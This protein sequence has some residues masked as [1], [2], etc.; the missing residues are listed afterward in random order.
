MSNL[1]SWNRLCK[2]SNCFAWIPEQY[3][4]LVLTANFVRATLGVSPKHYE[5][6]GECLTCCYIS[7]KCEQIRVVLLTLHLPAILT[8]PFAKGECVLVN[9]MFAY[10]V[11]KTLVTT[12]RKV[13]P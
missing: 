10:D 7:V 4:R 2:I 5:M 8:L 12:T 9:V 11:G 3:S 1:Q 6:T 13:E